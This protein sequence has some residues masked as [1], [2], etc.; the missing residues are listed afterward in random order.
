MAD[1][2]ASAAQNDQS[3]GHAHDHGHGSQAGGFMG[4]GVFYSSSDY[5]GGDDS[6]IFIAPLFHYDWA[7]GQ[8]V[9]VIGASE[10][11]KAVRVK[12]NLIT[13]EKSSIWEFG[14]LLQYRFGR[15]GIVNNKVDSLEGGDTAIELGAFAGLSADPW[16]ATLSIARDVSSV[17]DGTLA[18]LSSSYDMQISNKFSIEMS[19]NLTWADDIPVAL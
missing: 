9:S 4:L 10:A 13:K 12:G 17:H 11:E 8:Y 5:E 7:S 16:S 6:E 19:A 18:Y 1:T 15:N 3:F 2:M 14:P